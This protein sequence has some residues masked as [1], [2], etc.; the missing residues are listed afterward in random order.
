MDN[1][2]NKVEVNIYGRILNIK[3][4]EENIEYLKDIANFVNESMND[5]SM[6]Y[7]PNY[8]IDTIA[9]LACL[10][11][12]DLLKREIA[13]SKSGKDTLLAL[14][15]SIALRSNELIRLIDEIKENK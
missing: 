4:K 8:P 15:E 2:D 12:A 10:N 6:H 1:A 11:I 9:I 7:G 14:K 5:I 13:N 3:C